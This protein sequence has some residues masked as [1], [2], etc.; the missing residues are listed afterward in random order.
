[1]GIPSTVRPFAAVVV[2]LAGGLLSGCAAGS[3]D[4]AA[5]VA[6]TP[7]AQTPAAQT[8]AAP[9]AA[10]TQEPS[11]PMQQDLSAAS[12]C[13]TVSALSTVLLNASAGQQVGA[14]SESDRLALVR[15]ARFGYEHLQ[16]SDP[17]MT[18]AIDSVQRYLDAHPAPTEGLAIEDGPE[19][20][21]QQKLLTTACRESGSNV[22]ATAQ[23]GG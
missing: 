14:V 20:E 5:P 9:S 3:G 11:D 12:V 19:W 6:Q 2:L 8:P 17:R 15:S 10:Q 22:V 7:V 18:R 1:M 23:Y 16:S 13:G 21:L 4:S